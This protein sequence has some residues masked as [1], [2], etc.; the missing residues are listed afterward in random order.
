[1][2]ETLG[3]SVALGARAVRTWASNDDPAKAGDTA[4]QVAKLTYDETALRG[5][6]TA[7]AAVASPWLFAYDA[8][9]DHWDDYTFFWST[10]TTAEDRRSRYADVVRAAVL[11]R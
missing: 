7:G 1:M 4:I 9:P 8:R 3:K 2:E 6:D 11:A 5:L 10:G